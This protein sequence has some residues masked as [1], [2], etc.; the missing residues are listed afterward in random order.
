MDQLE[1]LQQRLGILPLKDRA[2]QSCLLLAA[3]YRLKS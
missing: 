3:S 1:Y 2:F